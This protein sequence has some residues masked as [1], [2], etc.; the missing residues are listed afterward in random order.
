MDDG[1]KVSVKSENNGRWMRE[2]VALTRVKKD[3]KSSPLN[4]IR[5]V[6]DV[7]P[8]YLHLEAIPLQNIARN[9]EFNIRQIFSLSLYV[10]Y[11]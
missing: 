11:M 4:E 5:K 6:R 1:G 3:Y 8:W 2:R 9:N 7:L 10:K